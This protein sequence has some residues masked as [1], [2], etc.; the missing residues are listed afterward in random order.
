MK[1]CLLY[2]WCSALQEEDMVV[3]VF[4]P[5]IEVN[6]S[7]YIYVRELWVIEDI[8]R[9]KVEVGCVELEL[10]IELLADIPEVTDLVNKSRAV[11]VALELT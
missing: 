1:E 7:K 10:G 4:L 6:K 9:H 3:G 5:K 2:F 8:G 11:V